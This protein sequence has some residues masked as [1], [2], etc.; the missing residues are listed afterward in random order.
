MKMKHLSMKLSFF[1][2]IMLA[3]GSLWASD[4]DNPPPC[5]NLD[6]TGTNLTCNGSNDGSA[7][8]TISGG[9]GD[10]TITWSTGATD[11]TSIS[12]LAA[13]YYDVEVLDNQSGC[14]RI[15]II[16]I[17]EPDPIQ[18]IL[19]PTDVKCYGD[20]SG[21]IAT[22]TTGG[23][24]SYTYIWSD[25]QSTANA[26]NLTAGNYTVTIT[27][28]NG[29]T[30]TASDSIHQPFQALGANISASEISCHDASDANVEV[31]VWGGTPYYT[32]TWNT[33]ESTQDLSNV[34]AGD[35]SLTITDHNACTVNQIVS[36][37]NP[38]EITYTSFSTNNDCAGY[39][40]GTAGV[41]VSGGTQPYTYNWA[42]SE[43]MLSHDTAELANL[44]SDD[45]H[46]TVTDAH[47]CSFNESFTVTSPPALEGSISSSD[48]SALGASDGQIDLEVSGGT[49]PYTYSWSNEVSTQDN[50]DV[51]AGTY[52]VDIMDSNG[53][54]L[55]LSVSI[56]EPQEALG[57]SYI[58]SD[59]SCNNGSDGSISI[60][61]SGGVPPYG[62]AWSNGSTEEQLY[63]LQAGTYS[64]T[65]TDDNGVSYSNTITINE[66]DPIS[67][68]YEAQDI[69]CFAGSDGMI[70]VSVSGGT[71]PYRYQWYDPDFA[72]A[73]VEQDISETRAGEYM[74]F[75][76]DTNDCEGSITITLN[77]PEPIEISLTGDDIQCHG[78]ST[79]NIYTEVEGG[80][81]DYSF[82]WS[83]GSTQENP[84]NLPADT[85]MLTVTDDMGCEAFSEISLYQ[86]EAIDISMSSVPVSC[87]AQHDGVAMAEASGGSGAFE[88]LWNTG[89]STTTIED[90]SEGTYSLT[91]TDIFDCTAEDS[92]LVSKSD[93]DCINIPNSFT[94]NGDGFNDTW[95][96]RNAYLFD[97]C[98]VRVFNKWGTIVFESTGYTEA[99]DGT[100]NGSILPSGTYYY[101]FKTTPDSAERTG[102]L[103]ILK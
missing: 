27:D 47:G 91:V 42:S 99:W 93:V 59:V 2:V 4:S 94:P 92:V 1:L 70:D 72:L 57:F 83:N 3:A 87:N 22:S 28:E 73:S 61:P 90:L 43:Y 85:Y 60:N 66:P 101:V 13:G 97:E 52:T 69:S 76:Q 20:A 71:E 86:P 5:H 8:I 16:N 54:T 89:A 55:E 64:C 58:S 98:Y 65:L 7:T 26:T 23:T 34:P 24:G 53:C 67:L 49:P 56:Q 62:I 39:T 48:A 29:C 21:A 15:E 103:T 45:Y 63:N 75:V 18:T 30:T 32:Y 36:I 96:I 77:Q 41:S 102:T 50:P 11:V 88:Y 40:E 68:T 95:V 78:A 12:N 33:G 80:T 44:T 9:S 19:S 74:L 31:N 38:E 35:Y 14:T 37:S 79:G 51:P 10:F 6:I 81:P 100:Y 84:Q 25:G 82:N 17:T 46:L